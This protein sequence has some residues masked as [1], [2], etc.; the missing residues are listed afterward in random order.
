M[1]KNQKKILKAMKKF[2]EVK[3]EDIECTKCPIYLSNH[4]CIRNI[5]RVELEKHGRW[6]F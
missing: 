2:A 3:C 6:V 4:D 5:T 1:K